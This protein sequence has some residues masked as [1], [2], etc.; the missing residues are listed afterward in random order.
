MSISTFEQVKQAASLQEYAETKLERAKRGGRYVCPFCSSGGNGGASSDS[1]FHLRGDR[2][3]CFSCGASGDIFDL[4][5]QVEG[6]PGKRAQLEAV[7]Q[8][9]G[10]DIA[11]ITN[12]P[13]ACT[14]D[15]IKS[16]RNEKPE[17]SLEDG[18]A[19]HEAYLLQARENIGQ[20]VAYLEQ[21]GYTL[22][23]A[24]TWGM[25]Y[26]PCKQRLI[27]PWKG[28]SYYH[29]D[30]DITG[31]A[32]NKYD[33]PKCDEVGAQPLYNPTALDGNCFFVVEGVFDALAM[34]ALGFKAVALGGV[35]VGALI[36]ALQ[37]KATKPTAI[38][39]LDRDSAGT[40]A[41][42]KAAQ[43][44]EAA[45]LPYRLMKWPD[46]LEGKD[47]DEII[48]RN[49]TRARELLVN[50]V[51]EVLAQREEERE[52][53]YREALGR[54]RVVEAEEV[55]TCVYLMDGATEPT[56]TGF[57]E[58]DET[59]DGGLPAGLTTLGAIS[60][61]GKTTF[62]VQI[63]DQIAATGRSVLFVTIEQAARELVAKSLSRLTKTLAKYGFDQHSFEGSSAGEILNPRRRSSW[64]I[65]QTQTLANACEIYNR[66][67]APY[68]HIME[69]VNQPSVA[70][71]ETLAR[72]MTAHDEKPPV[73][74][75]DYL[76]LLAQQSD[77][78]T[79]KQAVDKNVMILR[80]LA[81]ELQTPVV[82]ISSLNRAAYSTGVT[83]ESF[84]ESGAIEYGSDLLLGLQ[85]W[86]MSRDLQDVDEK[87]SKAKAR[88]ILSEHKAEEA[89]HCELAI[90]KNRSGRVPNEGLA[91]TF[92]APYS[93]WDETPTTPIYPF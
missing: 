57:S 93:W 18:R 85:P 10:I 37:T 7:A 69:G 44:F 2:Y 88:E 38:L 75:I 20:A 89:R 14:S 50:T 6:I 39:C 42:N 59:L 9:A 29:I 47:P 11:P 45:H 72:C 13:K 25:G 65:R 80:Q 91:Y 68:M 56:P 67:I 3:T 83:L 71:I 86:R 32:K 61:I 30:R 52:A 54:L 8:W 48:S 43:A 81:R 74:F 66:T 82:I 51:A 55:A 46:E 15:A 84:K 21:R 77:R 31:N 19:K 40:D 1:A 87:K 62:A 22:E 79:D 64:S 36:G 35:G 49:S 27:I 33:K 90:L 92:Y 53:A 12:T 17:P 76:Q 34:E 24:Q 4:A 70:D 26:D 60:S 28:S 63:A 78:D 16:H 58:L 5:G 41:A 73:I 23:Q